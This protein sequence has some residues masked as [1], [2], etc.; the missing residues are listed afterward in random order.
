MAAGEKTPGAFRTIGELS[1]ELGVA[2]HILRYWETR[3][4]SCGR[5]SAPATAAITGPT[6]SLWRGGSTACSTT[7]AIPSAASSNC[8]A[9]RTRKPSRL[10]TAVHQTVERPPPQE[11]EHERGVDVF[12]L[13]TLRDRLTRALGD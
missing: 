5:C 7:K 12:R 9:T 13:I 3:F 8:S 1:Q 4:P 6:T 11:L 10:R 2:Q